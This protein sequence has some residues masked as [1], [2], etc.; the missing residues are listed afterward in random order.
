MQL[1]TLLHLCAPAGG[2]AECE[3]GQRRGFLRPAGPP[4]GG[5]PQGELPPA[6]GAGG[7]LQPPVQTGDGD[8][9]HEGQSGDTNTTTTVTVLTS[10]HTSIH[11]TT[12]IL[13][14]V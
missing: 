14:C 11:T 8:L 3:D 5:A 7:Q 6:E 10:I 13:I 1:V 4:G 2:A 12:L 9:R